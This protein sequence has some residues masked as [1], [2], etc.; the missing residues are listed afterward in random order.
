MLVAVA[1]L[2]EENARKWAHLNGFTGS[3]SELCSLSKLQN[4]ILSELKA[5]SEKNKVTSA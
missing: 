3:L 2:H 1:V 4:Y 5:T